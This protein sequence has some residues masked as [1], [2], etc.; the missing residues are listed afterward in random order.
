MLLLEGINTDSLFAFLGITG[1]R[2]DQ[3]DGE[4]ESATDN[5]FPTPLFHDYFLL[6]DL[7]R[8]REASIS[9]IRCFPASGSTPVASIFLRTAS[10]S[11]SREALSLL[12]LACLRSNLTSSIRHCRLSGSAL[13]LTLRNASA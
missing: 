3:A 7:G 8:S 1:T 11:V 6:D 9:R 2:H 13:N 12:N 10:A 4:R 5:R